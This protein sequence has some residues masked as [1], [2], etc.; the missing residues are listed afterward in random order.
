MKLRIL[1]SALLILA[2]S[3][4]AFAQWTWL[5]PKP[6][7]HTLNDVEFL[8]DNT[9]IAVGDAGTIMVT[10]DAGLTWTAKIKV[11]D[12]T[13]QL[14]RIARVD[15][16]TAVVVGNAGVVLRTFDA[17]T[18]WQTLPSPTTLDIVDVD[19]LGSAG[20]VGAGS[21]VFR[22]DDGGA[23]WSS[24]SPEIGPIR[25]CELPAPSVLYVSS[26]IML[27]RSVDDGQT[28]EGLFI[29]GGNGNLSF[30]NATS[31][32]FANHFGI[33]VTS[34]A[35]VTWT[36][37]G[38]GP[39]QTETGM[40]MTDLAFRDVSLIAFSAAASICDV[41]RP[42]RCSSYGEAQFSTNGGLWWTIDQVWPCE[43]FGVSINGAGVMLFV[44]EGGVVA[45]RVPPAPILVT[46]CR[47][48][49]SGGTSTFVGPDRG[50][51]A[52]R[53]YELNGIGETEVVYSTF[54]R[55]G[56]SGDSWDESF[57]Y[58]SLANDVE[59][60][61]A[62][63]PLPP[64]YA[65]GASYNPG[66]NGWSAQVLKSTDGGASWSS[67]WSSASYG[68]LH[69]IDFAS[70]TRAIVVGDGGTT[71]VIN[72][73]TATPSTIPAGGSL[74]DVSFAT[75]SVAVAVGGSVPSPASVGTMLR[76]VSGGDSW[77]PVAFG[78]TAGLNGIDFSTGVIGVAVGA[79]GTILRTI[80]GGESWNP[81]ASPT[82]ADL[83]G[84]AFGDATR[85][86]IAGVAGTVLETSDGGETWT[87]IESPTTN[88]LTDVE[89][90]G[91]YQAVL[92]GPDQT[93]L[94]YNL[95]P[96]PTLIASFT[97]TP[98]PFAIDL[99]WSVRDE[100][101]LAG[102]RIERT[103]VATKVSRSFRD[104][105]ASARSFRDDSV[106]P[107]ATYD[108]VLVAIDSDGTE[109]QSPT[110]CVGASEAKLELLP[111]VPN[112]FNPSTTIRYIL[113]SRLKVRM[114]IYDVAGRAVVV[115][116][117]REEAAGPYNVEWNGTGADGARVSSGV[118]LVRIEAGTQSL[119]RK[120]V[121]LK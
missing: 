98:T 73:D 108:Y 20:I 94:E 92:V 105:S 59:F 106:V 26:N 110:I 43:L 4:P 97:G 86:F 89:V 14:N 79:L 30:A 119:S 22:T 85:G 8:D 28:W 82:T 81:V 72:G 90:L 111:N 29:G 3:T 62:A 75:A 103:D 109:T 41:S 114:T 66:T 88:D 80:D 64:A 71:V 91:A 121:L 15:A 61:P 38:V 7:G 12:I 77:T 33:Y 31:G 10:H 46:N 40:D 11:L 113:P 93:V 21:Q 54:L 16:T 36:E 53:V 17:G 52:N 13:T 45:R 51:V 23:T 69:A 63:S 2:T 65:A 42:Y 48:L 78:T 104:I 57:A 32:A 58:N 60:A 83:N 95:S 39:G 34:D 9:A 116:V 24:K 74:Q 84:I 50:I 27:T 70:P 1:A 112:P 115:L 118:Y 107:G 68:A 67:L 56:D 19:F 117:D 96:V 100:A 35:G 99:A 102:F 5:N 18:S 101:E 87:A 37:H 47:P 49:T 120:M 55:T 44:G 25:A 6:Q 76:T